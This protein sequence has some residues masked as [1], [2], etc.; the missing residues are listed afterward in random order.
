MA[1]WMN[2]DPPPV[3]VNVVPLYPDP[4]DCD[5]HGASCPGIYPSCPTVGPWVGTDSDLVV[6]RR[7][8]LQLAHPGSP[9]DE[10]DAELAL[11]FPWCAARDG[12]QCDAQCRVVLP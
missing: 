12:H 1:D 10:E 4:L 2:L 8:H 6:A 11:H 7:P 3:G 5:T 9:W